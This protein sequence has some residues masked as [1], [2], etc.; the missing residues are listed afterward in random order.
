MDDEGLAGGEGPLLGGVSRQGE[1]C[2]KVDGAC[3][4]LR[5]TAPTNRAATGQYNLRVQEN[6]SAKFA[7]SQVNG[8]S[9]QGFSGLCRTAA[10]FFLLLAICRVA[11]RS[12]QE[13]GQAKHFGFPSPD[14][15]EITFSFWVLPLTTTR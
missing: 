10:Y 8:G 4:P 13:S 9:G 6:H 11:E 3:Y 15:P 1:E 12:T 5:V 7:G 14:I 2:P